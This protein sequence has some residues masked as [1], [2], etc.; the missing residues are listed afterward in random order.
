MEESSRFVLKEGTPKE[1]ILVILRERV[2]TPGMPVSQFIDGPGLE[3]QL[4]VVI[5]TYGA[6]LP[7]TEELEL[8]ERYKQV[9]PYL[10]MQAEVDGTF[11]VAHRTYAG[12]DTRL[13]GSAFIGLGGHTQAED[14]EGQPFA[15]WWK[16]EFDEEVFYGGHEPH[17]PT[18]LGMVNSEVTSVSKVHLGLVYL[19]QVEKTIQLKE[20]AKME[21]KGWYTLEECAELPNFEEWSAIV[22]EYL[23]EQKRKSIRTGDPV[24]SGVII[25]NIGT[26]G[27]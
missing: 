12:S 21:I 19:F 9:I 1:D 17:A 14:V 16:R 5:M 18:F 23:L 8:D 25:E 2:F 26:T 6:F 27:K 3:K 15:T 24:Q 10:I 13:H 7:R 20:T 22:V 11:L 4:E